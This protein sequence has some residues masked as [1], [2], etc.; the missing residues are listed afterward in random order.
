MLR[1][2]SPLLALAALLPA[3]A[4]AGELVDR[5]VVVVNDD[6]V[7]ESEVQDE[8]RLYLEMDPDALPVG[9]EREAALAE[10]REIVIEGLVGRRLMDQA[11]VRLGITVEDPEVEAQ[12]AET[13]RMNSMSV[14][15]LKSQLARQ[16]IPLEE[17][18]TDLREQLKQFKLFQAEIGTKVDISDDQLRQRYNERHA[19]V[20]DDPELHLRVIILRFPDDGNPKG[21]AEVRGRADDIRQ[22]LD[23]GAAFD[24]LARQYSQDPG[25]AERGGDFGKVRLNGLI[26]ELREAVDGLPLNAVSDPIELANNTLWLVQVFRITNAA[27]VSFEAVRDQLFSELYQEE[28][29]RQIELWIEREKVRSHIERLH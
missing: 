6:L 26:P 24:Q 15:Q 16:G 23:A 19:R 12:M 29:E 28:E 13:A 9:P 7:L 10:L 17:F 25:S 22:Q 27:A 11:V 20:A 21:I 8:I 1:L 4:G 18:R 3:L 2:L 5:I 14:D